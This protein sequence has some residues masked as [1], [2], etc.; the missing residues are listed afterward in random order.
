M[1]A[2]IPPMKRQDEVWRRLCDEIGADFVK[3]GF[4]RGNKVQAHPG[5]WTVTFDTYTVSTGQSHVTYTRIRAPYLSIDGFRFAL[6]RRNLLSNLR[7]LLGIQDI[8][9]GYPE[10][11]REFVVKSNN[12]AK[13][14][15]LFFNEKIRRLVREQPSIRLEVKDDEGWFGKRFPEGVDELCFHVRGSIR[16]VARLKSLYI[17]FSEV[18]NELCRI[19]SA[20]QR[21]PQ[22]NI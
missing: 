1:R 8:E 4:L 17:L 7:R 9:T 21:N 15:A 3:G 5:E 6:Y 12:Q 20:V 16:D 2:K 11:D 10:F 19:G 14:M 22:F 13:A 18:L